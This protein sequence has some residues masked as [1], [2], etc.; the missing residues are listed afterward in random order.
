MH[1]YSFR[2]FSL[3]IVVNAKIKNLNVVLFPL[4]LPNIIVVGESRRRYILHQR[5][6]CKII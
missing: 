3:G 6:T 5:G 2:C 4:C 1:H